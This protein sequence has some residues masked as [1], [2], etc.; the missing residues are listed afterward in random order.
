MCP[1][2][3]IAGCFQQFRL[4]ASNV[5]PWGGATHNTEN[6]SAGAKD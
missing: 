2:L 5:N 3:A 4:L 6:D 1:K